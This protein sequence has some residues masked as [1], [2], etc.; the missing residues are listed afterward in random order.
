MSE[1]Q[2][3]L[4]ACKDDREEAIDISNDKNISKDAVPS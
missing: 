3:G 1:Q 4:T 2:E